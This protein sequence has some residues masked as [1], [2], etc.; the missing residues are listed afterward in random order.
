ME[1]SVL[2]ADLGLSSFRLLNRNNVRLSDEGLHTHEGIDVLREHGNSNGQQKE[3]L[4][5]QREDGNG[6]KDDGL[7]EVLEKTKENLN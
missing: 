7:V 3:S 4:T 6:S 5:D 2:E 1:R